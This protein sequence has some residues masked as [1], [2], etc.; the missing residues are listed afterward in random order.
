MAWAAPFGEDWKALW[1]GCPRG[2]WLLALAARAEVESQ[3]I[4]A[5]AVAVAEEVREYTEHPSV[6]EGLTA[7]RAGHPS[8]L[9]SPADPIEDA[10]LR[11][12]HAAALAQTDP[13]A[14]A[15]VA[16]A[17]AHLAAVDAGDCAMMSAVAYAH[18]R[19]AT[20]VRTI[21]GVDDLA[22]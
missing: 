14:A 9:P 1:D 21:I 15:G 10:A 18:H 20:V 3:K 22:I 12:L 16:A 8:E 2:D 19:A 4:A 17:L 13:A 11:A 5:A 7:L 6:L